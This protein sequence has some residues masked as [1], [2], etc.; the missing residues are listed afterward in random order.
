VEVGPSCGDAQHLG[1][2]LGRYG[3]LNIVISSSPLVII[4]THSYT[5]TNK[6][7][8]LTKIF[9]KW[10]YLDQQRTTEERKGSIVHSCH[11]CIILF[12]EVWALA[13]RYQGGILDTFHLELWIKHS[14]QL[15]FKLFVCP[16][17]ALHHSMRPHEVS[18]NPFRIPERWFIGEFLWEQKQNLAQYTKMAEALAKDRKDYRAYRLALQVLLFGKREPRVR[19][20]VS[21]F[22][23]SPVTCHLNTP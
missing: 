14:L 18:L 4:S 7:S 8:C 13:F 2:R 23:L 15:L 10:M 19:F 22:H 5:A 20:V 12:K 11:A 21:F 17:A 3:P 16:F 6:R 1:L 9:L